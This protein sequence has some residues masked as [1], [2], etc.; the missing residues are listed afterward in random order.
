MSQEYEEER[1]KLY[2]KLYTALKKVKEIAKEE[3]V[4]SEEKLECQRKVFDILFEIY[5][6]VGYRVMQYQ[7]ITGKTKL[8]E[9]LQDFFQTRNFFAVV[10]ELS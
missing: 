8:T 6:L 9:M 2:A 7:L 4:P 5:V 1:V 3:T 10:R